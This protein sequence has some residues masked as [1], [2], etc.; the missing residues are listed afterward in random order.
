VGLG[1]AGL[2]RPR[3]MLLLL[4]LLLSDSSLAPHDTLR[5]SMSDAGISRTFA[6][7]FLNVRSNSCTVCS[8]NSTHQKKGHC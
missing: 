7:A 2:V 5:M 3:V 1:A 6:Y 4:L 8:R